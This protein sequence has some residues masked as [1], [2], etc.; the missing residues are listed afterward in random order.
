[1]THVIHD[2]K[3]LDIVTT[4][5]IIKWSQSA[6]HACTRDSHSHFTRQLQL[7]GCPKLGQQH[8]HGLNIHCDE[9]EQ[10]IFR[11]NQ[12]A[13]CQLFLLWCSH[14]GTSIYRSY[15]VQTLRIWTDTLRIGACF[16]LFNM[17]WEYRNRHRKGPSYAASVQL[18]DFGRFAFVTQCERCKVESLIKY[19]NTSIETP[20]LDPEPSSI[21]SRHLIR[22]GQSIQSHW[23][24]ACALKSLCFRRRNYWKIQVQSCSL[25][26][27]SEYLP[28]HRTFFPALHHLL[29]NKGIPVLFLSDYQCSLSKPELWSD[30]QVLR[31][32][33]VAQP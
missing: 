16:G 26:E 13:W 31:T 4:Q 23:W 9:W 2:S 3:I 21:N 10:W 27:R 20:S 29:W 25:W 22:R 17:Y 24:V 5:K 28:R 30:F 7:S 14:C 6:L 33:C 32:T 12:S 1:M 18:V 19:I 11:L 8:H 15:E